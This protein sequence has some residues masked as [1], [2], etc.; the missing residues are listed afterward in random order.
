MYMTNL[1]KGLL[2]VCNLIMLVI[3]IGFMID[4]H[5]IRKINNDYSSIFSEKKYQKEIQITGIDVKTQEISC[6]Y[7]I[8]EM[9]S[10]WKQKNITEK[11]LFDQYGKVVTSTGKNFC[12]EMNK[13]LPELTTNMYVNLTNTELIDKIYDSLLNGMPVPFE[14]AAQYNGEW[15]LHYSLIVGINI[16]DNRIVIANPYGYIE[17]INTNEFLNRT[18]FSAYENMP[19]YIRLGFVFGVF[20]R[21][22][23]F[24]MK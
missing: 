23:I 15:T 22:A 5:R 6:G 17:N 8:I 18:S 9:I 16:P 4:N 14:W 2:I 24:I 1:I 3:I 20:E 10:T 12:S 19:F 11:S 21:N 13:Q 7:A